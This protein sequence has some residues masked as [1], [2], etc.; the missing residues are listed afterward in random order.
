MSENPMPNPKKSNSSKINPKHKSN[1]KKISK[2]AQLR[3]NSEPNDRIANSRAIECGV[4]FQ[5][6]S[7]SAKSGSKLAV[8]SIVLLRWQLPNYNKLDFK[9]FANQAHSVIV[10]VVA[11]TQFKLESGVT[12]VPLAAL[13]AYSN[14]TEAIIFGMATAKH[15]VRGGFGGLLLQECYRIFDCPLSCIS[16]PTAVDFYRKS[17]FE[18]IHKEVGDQNDCSMRYSGIVP[19]PV[20]VKVK[21]QVFQSIVDE[22]AATYASLVYCLDLVNR[23]NAKKNPTDLEKQLRDYVAFW[24]EHCKSGPVD[25]AKIQ[26]KSDLEAEGLNDLINQL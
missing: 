6:K 11:K 4:D 1:H 18:L 8:M 21:K 2:I 15:I 16:D 26:L 24:M 20:A 14:G 17:G 9:W 23:L 12:E 5:I 10:S 13:A 3:R 7:S 25:E 19:I 22:I